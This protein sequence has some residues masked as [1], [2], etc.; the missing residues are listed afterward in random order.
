MCTKQLILY[1][2]TE[3]G[4]YLY[5]A[6]DEIEA[7]HRQ[8][9]YDNDINI[10]NMSCDQVRARNVAYRDLVNG[11]LNI[12]SSMGDVFL[13][14]GEDWVKLLQDME[15]R[16]PGVTNHLFMLNIDLFEDI[17]KK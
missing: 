17:Y 13:E 4:G 1:T 11:P 16:V 14:R 8:S 10:R 15:T 9:F 12:S 7:Y 3:R 2:R 5:D 6:T